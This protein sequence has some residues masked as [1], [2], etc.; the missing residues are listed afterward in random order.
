M[1]LT[2]IGSRC[3][4]VQFELLWHCTI[5]E[6]RNFTEKGLHK[7]LIRGLK[8]QLC[9]A[10]RLH[11]YFCMMDRFELVIREH[12]VRARDACGRDCEDVALPNIASC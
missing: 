1:F 8:P 11:L 6:K 10:A 2:F 3:Q 7:A 4:S 5:N 12:C 9:P